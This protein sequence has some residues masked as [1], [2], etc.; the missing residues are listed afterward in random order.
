L[1]KSRER[2]K[3]G[4]GLRRRVLLG[5]WCELVE[6]TEEGTDWTTAYVTRA[7]TRCA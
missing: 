4:G 1:R 6:W 7:T 5:L 3:G 2:R